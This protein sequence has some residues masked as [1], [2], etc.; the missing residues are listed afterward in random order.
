MKPADV[1]PAQ[2]KAID[3]IY[4]ALRTKTDHS[5]EAF[6]IFDTQH[7]MKIL[8]RDFISGLEFLGIQIPTIEAIKLYSKF[9]TSCNGFISFEDF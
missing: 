6:R 9:D 4:V 5:L 1:S 2:K 8:F 7:E 3:Q